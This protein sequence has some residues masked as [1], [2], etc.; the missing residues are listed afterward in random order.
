MSFYRI[1]LLL[2]LTGMLAAAGCD[3]APDPD[4]EP[5]PRLRLLGQLS[6]E[7]ENAI[8]SD[9]WGY[10][11]SNTGTEYALIGG[12]GPGTSALHVVDVSDPAAPVLTASVNVPGFDMKVWRTYAYTVTGGGDRGDDPE[13]RIVDLSDPANPVVIGAFPSAHNIFIDDEG[14]LYLEVPGL[15]IMDLRADPT[16]PTLLWSD[17]T[18]N[19]HDASVI[20]DRLYDF[21][22]TGGTHI[23][24]VTN[25]A[26]P[27]VLGSITLPSIRYHHSG[28][29][30][31]DDAYLFVC[32]ELSRD[33]T[34][35]VTIWDIRDPADPVPVAEIGDLTA[36]VHNL[37]VIDDLAYVSYY[38]AGF[39]VYD[40]SDPTHPRL[41]DEYDT[42]MDV[43]GVG[44]NGAW[45]VY[46]FTPSGHLY[47][48]DTTN[49]LFVFAL[50]R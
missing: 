23:Y 18:R 24:D 10:V 42:A 30:T 36:T 35:D 49:G 11:D 31:P 46:P 26:A 33:S 21:H 34:A 48:S 37:Y 12:L 38:T 45:G 43:E 40:V 29:T 27:H 47:V 1:S 28:W 22:G 4:P 50:E 44:F 7:T 20:G 2:L 19:G 39:R 14:F 25:R 6:I 5:E 16:H 32:D 41:V 15:R 17:G 13:G 9:V 8:H 3:S